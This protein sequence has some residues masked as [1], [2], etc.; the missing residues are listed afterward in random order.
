MTKWNKLLQALNQTFNIQTGT[1]SA[2][3]P[4]HIAIDE[5][6]VE[7]V[8][9]LEYRIKGDVREAYYIDTVS[10]EQNASKLVGR[11][12]LIDVIAKTVWRVA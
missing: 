2:V 7:Q 12:R 5:D 4:L 10:I 9:W 8:I 1:E 6:A 11:K 3:K